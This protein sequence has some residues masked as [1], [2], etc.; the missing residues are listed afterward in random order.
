MLAAHF[1]TGSALSEFLA[2]RLGAP[3]CWPAE[4][5]TR[6]VAARAQDNSRYAIDRWENE[7]GKISRKPG[8]VQPHFAETA[9]HATAP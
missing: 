9:L 2:G 7:G 1:N 8:S 3:G 4:N 5:G 6:P